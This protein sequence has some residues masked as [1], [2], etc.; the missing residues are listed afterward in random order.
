MFLVSKIRELSLSYEAG[1][2]NTNVT[3]LKVKTF[4]VLQNQKI[5]GFNPI[6]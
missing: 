6:L 3:E 1:R 2:T 5:S 4:P